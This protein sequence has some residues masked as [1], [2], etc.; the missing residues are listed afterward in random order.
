MVALLAALCYAELAASVP[1]AGS[2]YTYAYATMGEVVAWIIGWDLLLEFALGAAVVARG[3]SGYLAELFGLPTAWFGEEGSV[4][5]VGAIA[6]VLLLGVVATI[7]IQQSARITNVLVVVK[8]AI[9][10]FVVVAGLFFISA[11]N[12]T[13]FVP[14]AE[15][16]PGDESG[17]TQPLTQVLFGLEPSVFGIAGVLSAA[18]VVFFAYTGF[19]A[20]ANLGEETRRPG[21]DLPLGVLGT[22]AVSAVLYI[23]VSFVIVGMVPYTEIDRGAPIA[24]A[25]NAVGAGWAAVLVSIAAVSGLTSVILVQ[26]VAMGRIGYAIARD[27]LIPTGIGAIHPRWGTPYRVTIAMTVL[28]AVLAG[29]LPLSA[30]ADL[31]SIGALFAFVIVSIAVPLVRRSRP[32]LKRPFRVPF[33]PVLPIVS[34]LACVYLMLNLSVE[35]W[36]RFLAWLLLGGLI[37]VGYGR[38]RNRLARQEH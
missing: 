9:C 10:I 1:T 18:A 35:T 31:V 5:N 19:E 28:V 23:G 6:I 26:L 13:P 8:V 25:F 37:Y 11:A 17:L 32:D 30:L 4:V 38:R 16:P 2:A 33:S 27:G 20:V 36:L 14:P 21:R 24:A 3:W 29:F 12:L 22:L 7:G 15:A 34:A